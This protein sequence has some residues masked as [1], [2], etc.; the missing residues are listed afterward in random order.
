MLT[1]NDF[2]DLIPLTDNEELRAAL[3]TAANQ[4][5]MLQRI[6]EVFNDEEISAGLLKPE[7]HS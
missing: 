3:I 7:T 6:L 4:A 5:L 2:M 1:Q